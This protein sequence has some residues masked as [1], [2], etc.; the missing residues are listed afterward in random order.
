MQIEQRIWTEYS[1]EL[2]RF[3][4]SKSK[5]PELSKE[6]VQDTLI[7]AYETRHTLKDITKLKSWLFTIARHKLIDKYRDKFIFEVFDEQQHDH[8]AAEYQEADTQISECLASL[9]NKLPDLYK[10]AVVMS[11]LE[12]NK[13]KVVAEKLGLSLSGTKSRVQRGRQLLKDNLF[14][15]C[16]LTF[17]STGQ[18]VSCEGARCAS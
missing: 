16:P 15:C 5:D 10:D 9:A 12:G 1:D 7:K 13:Q 14:A 6:I 8:E 17:N 11:D 3:I 2:F 4:V 18:P